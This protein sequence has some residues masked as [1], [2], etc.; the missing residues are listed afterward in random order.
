MDGEESRRPNWESVHNLIVFELLGWLVLL[1]KCIN[2][3]FLF[4]ILMYNHT[5]GYVLDH[6]FWRFLHKMPSPGRTI[7]LKLGLCQKLIKDVFNI[8]KN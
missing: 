8:L 1:G 4:D 5:Y 2:K 3:D 6:F 7:D